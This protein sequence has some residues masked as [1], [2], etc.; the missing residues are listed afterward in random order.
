MYDV[1]KNIQSQP[2]Q[3]STAGYLA[4]ENTSLKTWAWLCSLQRDGAH[5]WMSG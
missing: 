4:E 1:Y 5:Q 2:N 3:L